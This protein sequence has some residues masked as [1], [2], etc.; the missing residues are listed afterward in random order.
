MPAIEVP[1]IRDNILIGLKGIR[2]SRNLEKELKKFVEGILE[3]VYYEVFNE[4]PPEDV[5][6]WW[7]KIDKDILSY[8]YLSYLETFAGDNPDEA[9]ADSMEIIDGRFTSDEAKII[10]ALFDESST[11]ADFIKNLKKEFGK[12]TFYYDKHYRAGDRFLNELLK[13]AEKLK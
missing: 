5:I 6:N 2:L 4:K 3:E 7:K 1:G 9:T 10:E 11:I 13:K 12:A 8:M